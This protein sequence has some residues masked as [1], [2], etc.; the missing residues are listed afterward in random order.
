MVNRGKGMMTVRHVT[1]Y[2]LAAM[3]AL[4]PALLKLVVQ[5]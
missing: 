2:A 4:A 3:V 5:P 1:R